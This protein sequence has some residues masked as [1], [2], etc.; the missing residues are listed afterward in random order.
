MNK[1]NMKI[2]IDCISLLNKEITDQ[3]S[4]PFYLRSGYEANAV[5]KRLL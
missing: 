2:I 5:G 4:T 1:Q 3:K